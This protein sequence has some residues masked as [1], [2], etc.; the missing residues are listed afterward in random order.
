MRTQKNT[1]KKMNCNKKVRNNMAIDTVPFLSARFAIP[2]Q[3]F[4]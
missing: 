1:V 3:L 4:R 2:K